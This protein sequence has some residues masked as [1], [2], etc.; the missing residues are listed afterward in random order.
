MS[1]SLA[2][3]ISSV[4]GIPTLNSPPLQIFCIVLTAEFPRYYHTSHIFSP[5]LI[6]GH[7]ILE[8]NEPTFIKRNGSFV[9]NPHGAN[10]HLGEFFW[11]GP[12]GGVGSLSSMVDAIAMWWPM[13]CLVGV[14]FVILHV[15]YI[16]Y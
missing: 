9:A 8:K 16:S 5:S 11:G 6:G 1:H 10:S 12:G 14:F 15:G 4:F 3:D 7:V 13:G 2:N